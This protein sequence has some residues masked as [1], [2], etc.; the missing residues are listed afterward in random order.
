MTPQPPIFM[1]PAAV[2]SS[3][4]ISRKPGCALR[5]ISW[6]RDRSPVA[7][8]TPTMRGCCERRATVGASRSQAVRLGTLYTMTGTRTASAMAEKC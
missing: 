4:L 2:A 3:P 6:P 5:R 7:S 8:L 1:S